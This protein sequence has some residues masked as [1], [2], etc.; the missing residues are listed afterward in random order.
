MSLMIDWLHN[1]IHPCNNYPHE[2]LWVMDI[3]SM[4]LSIDPSCRVSH[5][6]WS[7]YICIHVSITMIKIPYSALSKINTN[8]QPYNCAQ[9]FSWLQYQIR[10]SLSCTPLSTFTIG[11]STKTSLAWID[12]MRHLYRTTKLILGTDYVQMSAPSTILVMQ[13]HLSLV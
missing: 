11:A 12:L 5:F 8:S 9:S 4:N 1:D 10:S 7:N 6:S 2:N 13:G 3:S